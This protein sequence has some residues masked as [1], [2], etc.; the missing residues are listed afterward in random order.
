MNRTN[1][2]NPVDVQNLLAFRRREY[3]QLKL[4]PRTRP[5]TLQQCIKKGKWASAQLQ[6]INAKVQH[7]TLEYPSLSNFAA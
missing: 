3:V 5:V 4:N 2:W 6:R 7:E 1:I